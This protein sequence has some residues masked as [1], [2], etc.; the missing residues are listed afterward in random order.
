MTKEV[1]ILT[2]A[3][4]IDVDQLK[5]AIPTDKP[6]Y[7]LY[8]VVMPDRTCHSGEH[9]CFS[10]QDRIAD[11]LQPLIFY[12]TKMTWSKVSNYIAYLNVMPLLLFQCLYI[13]SLLGSRPSKRRCCILRAKPH[14]CAMLNLRLASPL[15]ER[16]VHLKTVKS[17]KIRVGG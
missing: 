9:I 12:E 7:N 13:R 4:T 10:S 17:L 1:I 8:S 2:A 3:D 6:R 16:C 15:V 11:T 14:S 5:D